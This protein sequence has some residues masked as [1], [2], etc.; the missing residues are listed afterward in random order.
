[1]PAFKQQILLLVKRILLIYVLFSLSRILFH[2]LNANHFQNM[3]GNEL[4][5]IYFYGLRFDTF[6]ILVCNS[7]FI[8]LSVLPI[9]AFNQHRFQTHLKR[10]FL[11][12]NSVFLAINFI[13]M[14]Y[15]KY[16]G[17]RS[18][19]DIFHQMGG[20]TDVMK[21][22]PYYFRDFW[23]IIL[24]YA[25]AVYLMVRFYP[26][27]KTISE[28]IY[29]Y[30]LKNTT[31]YSLTFVIIC[32]FTV[33]GL[34]GGLQRVPIDFAD[35]GNYSSPQHVSLVLNSPFTIIKSVTLAGLEEYHFFP[36]EEA[37]TKFNPV[38]HYQN[39]FFKQQNIVVLILESFS[40]EYTGL[41]KRKSLTPF[42]DSLMQHSLVFTNAWSNGI[43]SIEGIP[44]ILA[45][46]PSLSHD[47][48]VN[49]Q[50]CN[51]AINSFAS[52]LKR[53]N[54]Q[55]AFF[56]GGI[57][58][59]MNFDVFAKQAG[60]DK[61]YGKTEYNNDEDFD[62]N[63][64]IWD[65]PYLQYCAKE[66]SSFKEPFMAS[67]FTLSSHHPF[68]IPHHLKGKFP[69]NELENSESIGYAD[70]SVRKFF[71]TASKMPWYNNTL[72]VLVADHASLSLDPF[73]SNMVGSHMIPILFYKS[74]DSFK[75]TNNHL[76][77]HIDILPTVLDTIGYNESFFSLGK[78]VFSHNGDDYAIFYES[79]IH[80]L[81]NDSMLFSYNNLKPVHTLKY[82]VDSTL[83]EHIAKFNTK[84]ADNYLKLFLQVHNHVVI[85]N[86]MTS[87]LFKS[88]K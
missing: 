5:R 64:G 85:N 35:A 50:Y 19:Y 40:K 32:G 17:K 62:G 16:I 76:I 86:K 41:S 67:V 9:Q 57:N 83:S 31:G 46:L 79:G 87:G 39:K 44:A 42:L 28:N 33:L 26:K 10:W 37:Y 34:R 56:H 84:Q 25:G 20:Q 23:H 29:A 59:T 82:T 74:D 88:D 66:I 53:K 48:F 68:K 72:F 13:D 24:L 8:L 54:Y 55:T 51:N 43:K 15:F 49:S 1:M 70:Y 80:Y 61:Y 38:K 6:S 3:E 12:S 45:S 14:A 58:G 77:Q 30:S 21:Q 75:G 65:E 7:L 60:F 18:T 22:I 27:Q 73:Y 52:L 71:E 81:L 4:F 2:L 63:W 78:S 69:K 36:D 11:I 47:P